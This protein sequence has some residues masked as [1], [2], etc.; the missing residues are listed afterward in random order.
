[1]SFSLSKKITFEGEI[2][3]RTGILNDTSGLFLQKEFFKEN[4]EIFLSFLLV[5][6]ILVKYHI[7]RIS[8]KGL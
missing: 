8:Q 5:C 1:M 6:W 2:F 3:L 7:C 4:P